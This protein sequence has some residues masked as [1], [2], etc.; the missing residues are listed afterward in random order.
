ME[1]DWCFRV[2][3]LRTCLFRNKELCMRVN[4]VSDAVTTTTV[5]E[6]N[7][8]LVPHPGTSLLQDEVNSLL[9]VCHSSVYCM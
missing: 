9:L 1:K 7:S 3:S 8:S 6:R 2:L 5:R 4:T